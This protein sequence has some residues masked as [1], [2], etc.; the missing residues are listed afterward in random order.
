MALAIWLQ[1]NGGS[2]LRYLWIT[3]LL[4]IP[5]Q[6]AIASEPLFEKLNKELAPLSRIETLYVLRVAENR[7]A[8]QFQALESNPLMKDPQRKDEHLDLVLRVRAFSYGMLARL[9]EKRVADV[10]AVYRAR[11]EIYSEGFR[12]KAT[13]A[14]M[15]E[16]ERANDAA[17]YRVFDEQSVALKKSGAVLDDN[18]VKSGRE[19]GI[20][21]G[22]EIVNYGKAYA[23]ATSPFRNDKRA[24]PLGNVDDGLAA[25]KRGDY[26]LA[27]QIF[28]PLA[29]QGNADAQFFLAVQYDKG[30]G[31]A[32]KPAEALKWFRR[33]ADQGDYGAQYFLGTIYLI[34]KDVP[35]DLVAAH[36]WFSLAAAKGE[37]TA[38]KR[39]DQIE[40]IMTPAQLAEAKKRAS[41]W[42]PAKP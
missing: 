32:R 40:P 27:A 4:V 39:R 37:E 11:A 29:E 7:L 34:G 19:I 13:V 15:D 28:H 25:Q 9:L 42:K 8:D 12:G 16:L 23:L 18:K 26:A 21:F 36:M 20:R 38:A 10:A 6:S 35:H 24:K 41:A 22:M 30:Q 14:Q 2:M 31:V 33:A 1:K 17:K 3:L 5:L